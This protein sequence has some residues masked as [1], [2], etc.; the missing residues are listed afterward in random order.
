MVRAPTLAVLLSAAALAACGDARHPTTRAGS[1]CDG[2]HGQGPL[3]APPPALSGAIASTDPRVGA[4]AAHLASD[5]AHPPV[6]CGDCHV[7]PRT[8]GDPGHFT[9]GDSIVTFGPRARAG[10]AAPTYDR[11]TGTCASTACHAQP[12]AAVPAPRWAAG[13]L[14]GDRCG[15]CHGQP[16][17]RPHPVWKAC[18]RCHG[19]GTPTAPGVV[20]GPGHLSG[21][22]DATR[23]HPGGWISQHGAAALGGD[24][25]CRS[26]HGPDLF[27]DASPLSCN[28]CHGEGGCGACHGVPPATGAHAVHHDGGGKPAY[29]A[30]TVIADDGPAGGPRYRFGCGQCHPVDSAHHL[31]G[32]VEVDLSPAGAPAGSLKAR[33][34]AGAAYVKAPGEPAGRCSEVACHSS[35]QD[36]PVFVTTP[37]WDD[38]T[39]LGCD[40]C[41]GNPPRYASGGPGSP[42]ANSHVWV[43]TDPTLGAIA[44]GHWGDLPSWGHQDLG[45]PL[46]PATAGASPITCQTCHYD[47]V[48]PAHTGPSG[49]YYLDTTSRYDVEPGL[50][51]I[52][53]CTSCHTGAA[54]APPAQGGA[55]SP[56]KHVNGTRD[57][58]FDP[59][60]SAAGYARLPPAPN[61][62][63]FPYWRRPAGLSST[64][65]DVRMD[66]D[67][68]SLHLGNARWDAATKTCTNVACHLSQT[69]VTWGAT[70]SLSDAC[71]SCHNFF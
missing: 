12:G 52:V 33:N 36:A 53:G 32:T 19:G 1:S 25:S 66:G 7:V 20:P 38:P 59:R 54:G 29:G 2:C 47:T 6:S 65:A 43:E 21:T 24:A 45:H 51:G 11:T 64:R 57:L 22:V 5:L 50:A 67:T 31:D 49:F 18:D 8:V 34:G 40:G 28:T 37:R 39:G 55:V 30:V 68:L 13:A 3:G 14:P 70:T 15:H 69:S 16:P 26:C 17:P 44:G 41:H 56:L 4:H 63:A 42:T 35:G 58:A 60:T 9:P 48:D 71:K 62:P 23:F 61:I 10:G 46:D 27:S